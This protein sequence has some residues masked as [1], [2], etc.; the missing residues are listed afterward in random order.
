[1]NVW[2][3]ARIRLVV[4]AATFA[5][6]MAPDASAQY[7][8]RNKVQYKKLDFQVLKTEHFDIYFYPSAKE[9]VDIAARMAERWH[10]R[11]EKAAGPRTAR[12]PAARALRVASRLR[13]DQRHLGRDRRRHRR[14]HRVAPAPHHPAAGRA[15]RR[16]RSRDRPRAGARV[17]VRHHD[18]APTRRPGETGAASSPAV[19]HRRHGRVPVDRSGRRAH[20]DVAARRGARGDSCRTIEELDNPEVLSR[21]AGARRSGRTSAARWG[22]E[23]VG[24]MLSIGAGDRRLRG[25]HPARPRDRRARSCPNEW[26]AGDPRRLPRTLPRHDAAVGSR[27]RSCIKGGTASAAI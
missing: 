3:I 1:M 17:P 2:T 20:G 15:A 5:C 25:G 11:L 16:H 23:V 19:V 4:V 18:A 22:D 26:H 13:A 7:F 6:L 9:G 12:T 8:G 21:I 27:A 14:R 10:A 24:E